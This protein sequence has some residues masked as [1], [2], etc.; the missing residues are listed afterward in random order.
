MKIRKLEN[1][2]QT[3]LNAHSSLVI[4]LKIKLTDHFDVLHMFLFMGC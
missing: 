4:P 1:V 3:E 2:F